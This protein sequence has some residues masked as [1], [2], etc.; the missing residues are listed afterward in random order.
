M[1]HNSAVLVKDTRV[2]QNLTS[3]GHGMTRNDAI[4]GSV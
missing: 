4:D 2:F 3:R 1:P